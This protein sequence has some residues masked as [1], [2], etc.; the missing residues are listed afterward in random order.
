MPLLYLYVYM[1]LLKGHLTGDLY[2]QTEDEE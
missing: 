1:F 2:D